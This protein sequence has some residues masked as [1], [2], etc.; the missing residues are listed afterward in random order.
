M[1]QFVIQ[2]VKIYQNNRLFYHNF[3]HIILI[4]HNSLL[5]KNTIFKMKDYKQGNQPP[6]GPN[7][8]EH[9]QRNNQ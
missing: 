5:L 4:N 6:S 3:N 9:N 1:K 2:N 7:F 8:Q